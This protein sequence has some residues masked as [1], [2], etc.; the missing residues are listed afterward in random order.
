[1]EDNPRGVGGHGRG[2]PDQNVSD[3]SGSSDEVTS[4]S[5]EAASA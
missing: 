1:L 3:E 4:D 2:L 5:G